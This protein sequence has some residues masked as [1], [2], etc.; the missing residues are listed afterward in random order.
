MNKPNDILEYKGYH[1]RVEFDSVSLILHGK[2][3]GINDLVTFESDSV[4]EIENEFHKAVDDYLAFCENIG[5]SP[6]KE[7]RG[8][9]NIRITP[10]LHKKLVELSFLQ[11][12]SLNSTVEK[13]IDLYVQTE[14]MKM[15]MIKT[16]I[17]S[18]EMQS[19]Q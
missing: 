12:E 18:V 15:T 1:A 4:S 5:Q 8:S 11:N 6:D 14:E 3:E 17:P 2:I 16:E 9:F 7:Y 13:A 10:E 19:S